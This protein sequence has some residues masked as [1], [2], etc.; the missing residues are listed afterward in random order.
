V[1]QR[2][3][4]TRADLHGMALGVATL[5]T[6]ALP[7]FFAS[8]FAPEIQRDLDLADSQIGIAIAAFWVAATISSV[9]SGRM[10]DRIGPA[11]STWLA[12]L[13]VA[14]A[15]LG[16]AVL[17]DSYA[18]FVVLLALTGVGNALVAPALSVRIK[19]ALS[20]GVQGTTFGLQ[21][22]G[23][24][25]ASMV[26]GVALPAAAG[27]LGWRAVLA[28]GAAATVATAAT[29]RD[30]GDVDVRSDEAREATG[31]AGE[32]GPVHG[33]EAALMVAGGM[34]ASALAN[35]LLTYLVVYAVDE[36]M[37]TA[38]AGWVLTAASVACVA[39]RVALGA[40]ADRRP[41]PRLPQMAALLAIGAVGSA[42]LAIGSPWAIATGALLALGLG[43][44]WAGLYMLTAVERGGDT[45]GKAVGTATTGTFAGAIAGPLLVGLVADAGSFAAAWLACSAIALGGAAA[46]LRAGTARV[47][48]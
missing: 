25:L 3:R 37:S 18:Q 30:V 11:R 33:R 10:V 12:A 39:T 6:F 43:W 31:L 29:V 16:I 40:M 34:L 17:A 23:P 22:S 42:V 36:G 45:P 15:C 44:G 9:A 2:G 19:Q 1:I 26:A 21:Q 27:T 35:G 28:L 47:P 46:F 24:P 13:F 38:A 32:P 8:A 41:R 5:A 4:G 20:P 14:S 7:V 48:A